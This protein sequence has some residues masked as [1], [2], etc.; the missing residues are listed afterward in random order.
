MG[1]GDSQ[2]PPSAAKGMAACEDPD[3]TAPGELVGEVDP[4]GTV[5]GMTCN[6]QSENMPGMAIYTTTNQKLW[7]EWSDPHQPI[8]N[9]CRNDPTQ[10]NKGGSG[11]DHT[12]SSP[13]S[14]Q[15][16]TA[17]SWGVN[18]CWG[19]EGVV[20]LTPFRWPASHLIRWC[21]QIA[22]AACQD[23]GGEP[24]KWGIMMLNVHRN[25]TAY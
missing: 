20:S 14:V 12:T 1:G 4:T 2:G 17:P 11:L 15:D 6:S 19:W 25:L 23:L 21:P 7:Q 22:H 16:S 5:T 13:V 18:V 10:N 8:R 3:A 24:G 9:C